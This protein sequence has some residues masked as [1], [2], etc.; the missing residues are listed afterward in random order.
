M[1]EIQ[2]LQCPRAFILD[3]LPTVRPIWF[4]KLLR[5]S[6]PSKIRRDM[7]HVAEKPENYK[8]LIFMDSVSQT[9]GIVTGMFLGAL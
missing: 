2:R 6:R 3:P 1:D 7:M 8:N 4:H 5:N 9:L